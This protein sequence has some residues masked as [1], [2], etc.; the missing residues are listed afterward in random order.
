MMSTNYTWI[1]VSGLF[2]FCSLQNLCVLVSENW[3]IPV[4]L[5]L[6]LCSCWIMFCFIL[7][8]IEH[9]IHN[10]SEHEAVHDTEYF[11][12]LPWSHLW[13]AEPVALLVVPYLCFV[14]K[15]I[16]SIC[17]TLSM[18]LTHQ[19]VLASCILLTSS[20]LIKQCKC[21]DCA[22][23]AAYLLNCHTVVF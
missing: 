22:Y 4:L 14:Y 6:S 17:L 19:S 7:A 13:T 1:V 11:L 3:I 18:S 20:N 5:S 12:W 10:T 23:L 2:F 9:T 21:K 16:E 8:A 15:Y